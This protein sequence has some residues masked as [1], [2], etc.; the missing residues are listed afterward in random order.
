MSPV[1][2]LSFYVFLSLNRNLD[3]VEFAH[4]RK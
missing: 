4:V 2:H 1:V 3:F